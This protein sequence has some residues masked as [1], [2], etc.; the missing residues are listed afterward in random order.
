VRKNFLFLALLAALASSAWAVPLYVVATTAQS[1]GGPD[2]I[3]EYESTTLAEILRFP[4]PAATAGSQ[5]WTGVAYADN[6]LYYI[7]GAN[8]VLYELDPTVGTVLDQTPIPGGAGNVDGLA[9]MGGLV[10]IL[11]YDNNDLITFDPV[12]NL[13][14][15]TVDLDPNGQDFSGGL[16]TIPELGQLIASAESD[17]FETIALYSIDPITGLATPLFDATEMYDIFG[18]D[19]LGGI[20]YVAGFGVDEAGNQGDP[21]IQAYAFDGTFLGGGAP[22]DVT[23]LWAVG[24]GQVRQAAIPEPCTLTLVGLGLLATLRRRR[25]RR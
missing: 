12:T 9:T 13:V 20:A 1:P 3:I 19:S 14:T 4:V 25:N 11:D 2:F 17:Y 5:G 23:G 22:P 24:I 7:S 18:V 6:V 15:A 16:G 21:E 8:A 10:Y